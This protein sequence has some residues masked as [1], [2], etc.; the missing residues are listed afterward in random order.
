MN[1]MAQEI[2]DEWLREYHGDLKEIDREIEEI[3]RKWT[4]DLTEILQG[5]WISPT[6]SAN[7]NDY[8]E[9]F[10]AP[11]NNEYWQKIQLPNDLVN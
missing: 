8:W 4:S 7:D 11:D 1:N 2:Q 10:D 9:N 6:K 3:I 5:E